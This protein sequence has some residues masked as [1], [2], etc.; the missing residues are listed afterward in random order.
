[1]T[2]DGRQHARAAAKIILLVTYL[3]ETDPDR[4][5]CQFIGGGKKPRPQQTADPIR[6]AHAMKKSFAIALAA[7]AMMFA[8]QAP[9]QASMAGLST[10]LPAQTETQEAA[11]QKVGFKRRGGFRLRIRHGFR[12]HRFRH[13]Y[14]GHRRYYGCGRFYRKFKWTG[15]HYW[16]RRYRACKGWY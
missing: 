3:T 14:Y 6:K 13:H 5:D 12:H 9:A 10:T 2:T 4:C 16:L 7:A 15:S 1:M 11:V 8:A